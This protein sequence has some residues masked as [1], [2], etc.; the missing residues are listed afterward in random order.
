MSY[1][2]LCPYCQMPIDSKEM[3]E[4]VREVHGH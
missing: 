2:L 1:P 3:D 4:H